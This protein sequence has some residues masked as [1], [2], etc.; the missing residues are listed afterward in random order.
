MTHVHN[1]E[2]L[3][4]RAARQ[5]NDVGDRAECAPAHAPTSSRLVDRYMSSD[6]LVRSN[7]LGRPA[8]LKTIKPWLDALHHEVPLGAEPSLQQRVTRVQTCIACGFFAN[9]FLPLSKLGFALCTSES[10]SCWTR[11]RG[12]RFAR[13]HLG[14]DVCDLRSACV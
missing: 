5:A 13:E 12:Q 8:G 7:L 2:E 10:N 1:M 11:V 9:Q 14:P 6:F 3:L 4:R